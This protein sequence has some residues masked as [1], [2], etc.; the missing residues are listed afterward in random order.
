MSFL[1]PHI[2]ERE[3]RK[4]LDLLRFA[5]TSRGVDGQ[6]WQAAM[7]FDALAPCDDCICLYGDG[8]SWVV[9]YTERGTWREIARFPLSYDA[10]KYLFAHFIGG[11]SPYDVRED[12]ERKTGQEFSMVD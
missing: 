5:M 4:T 2:V 1:P 3:D 11:P 7:R 9:S 6:A 12:W 8:G 10:V